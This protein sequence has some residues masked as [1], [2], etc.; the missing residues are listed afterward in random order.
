MSDESR[1]RH[2]HPESIDPAPWLG[3]V[4][5]GATL[6]AGEY[7]SRELRELT[8]RA[9]AHREEHHKDPDKH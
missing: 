5:D 3:R 6:P 2:D 8:E 9:R 1:K 7:I 4:G